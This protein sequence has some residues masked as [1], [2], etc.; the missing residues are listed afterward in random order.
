MNVLL[1]FNP[2][3]P[4]N[5]PNCAG[6]PSSRAI[7]AT[8]DRTS[9][10]PMNKSTHIWPLIL[11]V[12][13]TAAACAGSAGGGGGGGY[14]GG[15]VGSPCVTEGSAGCYF[16]NGLALTET[17]SGGVWTQQQVC[18]AGTFCSMN[19]A[20]QAECGATAT[21]DA[22]ADTT[23]AT[24]Q[25]AAGADTGAPQSD[26]GAAQSDTGAAQS[27]T[28]AATQSDAGTANQPDTSAGPKPLTAKGGFTTTI[29]GGLHGVDYAGMAATASMVHRLTTAPN[30]VGCV[31]A[32]DIS[33]AQPGGSCRLDLSFVVG[34]AGQGLRLET[35]RF[36][37]RTALM[38]DGQVISTLPCKGWTDEPSSGP[39]V[40]ESQGPEGTISISPLP[41]PLASQAVATLPDQNL[42]I[43]L[44]API[45]MKFGARTFSL[46]LSTLQFEGLLTSNGNAA[47]SCVK[48]GTPLPDWVLLDVNPGSK[49]YKNTYGL[50]AFQGKKVVVTL[51]SDW[52]N[53]CRA[54]AQLVQKLQNQVD[55]SGK[56]DTQ[57]VLI[58]DKQKSNITQ[59][60]KL[61]TNVPI[62]QDTSAVNAWTVMNKPHAGKFQGSAIRNSSYGFAKNG[63]DIM[64]FAP[65][66][67][68]GLN[69]TAFQ[70]AVMTVINAAD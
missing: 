43:T 14:P 18:Q 8:H 60:T 6:S 37:A 61:V 21:I 46:N 15:V 53:S 38:Q 25:D 63:K 66:G 45:V 67:S 64:Y 11:A 16:A 44:D 22:G 42:T 19:S 56:A 29:D 24:A 35:V 65:N 48:Q 51:V 47:A 13:W 52:C 20:G 39:V 17:C 41:Q 34:Y 70:N 55:N 62:F 54:Q 12:A 50:S 69:L 27:D 7:R 57:L 33:V 31:T 10:A 40:Y 28:G 36:H 58:A 49:G 26:T 4:R 3:G 30:E 2:Y 23:T 9:G 68:G 32:L 5:N 1:R 59:L